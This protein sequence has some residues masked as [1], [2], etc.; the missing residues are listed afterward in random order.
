M[1]GAVTL[2][3]SE[4]KNEYF[5]EISV[6]R[7]LVRTVLSA[8]TLPNRFYEAHA[9]LLEAVPDSVLAFCALLLA[10]CFPVTSYPGNEAT[11]PLTGRYT[12]TY[13]DSKEFK[14]CCVIMNFTFY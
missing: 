4:D 3:F 2:S 9:D 11:R 10:F 8:A 6:R 13:N 1:A 14:I 7:L 5:G 12:H